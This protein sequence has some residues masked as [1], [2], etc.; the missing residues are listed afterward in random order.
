MRDY[1]PDK[2][3]ISIH[4]PKCAGTS[5][6]DV[7]KK[8]FGKGLH[9]HYYDEE[10]DRPPAKATFRPG[11]FGRPRRFCVHGHF[12]R[13]RGTGPLDYYPDADQY[14]TI[15]RDPFEVH[16][17]H[18]F[19]AKRL[20]DNLYRGGEAHHLRD[21]AYDLAR[22]LEEEPRSFLLNYMP[23]PLTEDDMAERIERDFVYVGVAEDLQTSV[24]R[25]ADRLGFKRVKV[26]TLNVA[27]RYENLPEGARERFRKDNPVECAL[28]DYALE[29]Y[30]A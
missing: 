21:E 25:L 5:F 1:D 23:Y 29:R 10:H 16:V 30:Q 6:N 18:F 8:W 17:S 14:I 22:Y 27:K 2:P 11:L 7:L 15:L 13:T 19:W 4:I 9:G 24:D 12:N 3:L 28:Y 20:G 26:P